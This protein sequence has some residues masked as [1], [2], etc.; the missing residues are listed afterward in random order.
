MFPPE[1]IG[2]SDATFRIMDDWAPLDG[3]NAIVYLNGPFR[4]ELD[5]CGALMDWVHAHITDTGGHLINLNGFFVSEPDGTIWQIM[6][7]NPGGLY[8]A[9]DGIEKRM[10]P[11]FLSK[12]RFS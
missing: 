5:Y 10:E 2:T 1:T 12:R 3:E 9:P 7:R 4:L 6:E 11:F 8:K